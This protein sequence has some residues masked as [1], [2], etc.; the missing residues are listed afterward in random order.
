VRCSLHRGL[1]CVGRGGDPDSDP[2]PSMMR[3]VQ[4][5]ASARDEQVVPRRG[6]YWLLQRAI[7]VLRS[8]V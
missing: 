5:L 2:H 1:P 6:P 7:P 4:L 8:E 3:V